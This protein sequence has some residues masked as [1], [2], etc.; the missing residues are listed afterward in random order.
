MFNDDKERIIVD[1]FHSETD[2]EKIYTIYPHGR[3]IG[4][5]PKCC[6]NS[7]FFA[8]KDEINDF[9]EDHKDKIIIIADYRT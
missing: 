1:E 5:M 6:S 2:C 4:T 7:G 8:S 3:V 9:L